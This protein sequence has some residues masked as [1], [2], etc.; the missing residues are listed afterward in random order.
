[1]S[2]TENEHINI[3]N[4]LQNVDLPPMDQAW[5]E[6]EVMLGSSASGWLAQLIKKTIYLNILAYVLIGGG[7]LVLFAQ[8]QSNAQLNVELGNQIS[9]AD[10]GTRTSFPAGV[11]A[12]HFASSLDLIKE[13]EALLPLGRWRSGPKGFYIP[14]TTKRST[15]I[16]K[17]FL[18]DEFQTVLKNNSNNLPIEEEYEEPMLLI[19][20]VDGD[21]ERGFDFI[22]T[23]RP[24]PEFGI[25]L[26]GQFLPET[27]LTEMARTLGYGLYGR[28]YISHANSFQIECNYNPTNI[29]SMSYNTS[30]TL[31]NTQPFEQI[32]SNTVT[33]LRYVSLPVLY[34]IEP[35]HKTYV[36]FGPQLSLLT[37]VHGENTRTISK[38]GLNESSE[39]TEFGELDQDGMFNKFDVSFIGDVGFKH[40]RFEVGLRLLIGFSDYSS[41]K[42]G[43]G[44]N[45]NGSLQ[46]NT[47]WNITK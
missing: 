7:I 22:K 18:D 9:E 13:N 35:T 42:F 46:I 29:R 12:N 32:D 39:F 1:M 14:N 31:V 16:Q 34:R 10:Y 4:K 17:T 27:K 8:Q 5:E 26:S 3:K 21:D 2:F 11:F 20:K 33:Q 23:T 43:A 47:A 24:K 45:T 40:K 28:F 25:K 15:K 30:T 44:K 37:S 19:K 41:E 6:M 36:M 38:S